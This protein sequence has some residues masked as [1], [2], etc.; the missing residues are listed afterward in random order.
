MRPGTRRIVPQNNS[1]PNS[2]S[3]QTSLKV[4]YSIQDKEEDL[5]SDIQS[6]V[7]SRPSEGKSLKV[8]RNNQKTATNLEQISEEN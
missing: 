2:L 1:G 3:E 4:N 8:A 6:I 5:D 7:D